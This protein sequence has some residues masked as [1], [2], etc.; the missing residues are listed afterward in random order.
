MGTLLALSVK[1]TN[2]RRFLRS[3]PMITEIL[4][5]RRVELLKGEI[6]E[7]SPEGETQAPTTFQIPYPIDLALFG[8]VELCPNVRLTRSLGH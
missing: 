7:M 5:N 6:V 4:N 3:R 2:K 1:L 8:A